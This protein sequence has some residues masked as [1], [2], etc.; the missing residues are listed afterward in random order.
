MGPKG[1]SQNNV[2]QM[3][4]SELG[5]ENALALAAALAPCKR[6]AY[7]FLKENGLSDETQKAIEAMKLAR[8]VNF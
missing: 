2:L 5:D 4:K 1:Y 8:S 7:L 3:N 6:I